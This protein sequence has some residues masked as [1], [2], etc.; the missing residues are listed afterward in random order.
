[1]PAE[2]AEIAKIAKISEVELRQVE[3]MAEIEPLVVFRHGLVLR[4]HA[5]VA[6]ADQRI[7]IAVQQHRERDLAHDPTAASHAAANAVLNTPIAK[8]AF[9]FAGDVDRLLQRQTLGGMK[10]DE[11]M[12]FAH[13]ERPSGAGVV[14]VG[15]RARDQVTY[16]NRDRRDLRLPAS[17]VF[18]LFGKRSVENDTNTFAVVGRYG[19]HV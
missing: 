5:V 2:I 6:V 16:S 7:D 17:P 3:Q 10:W 14:I 18:Q 8:G 1:M 12:A 15:D 13:G 19:L 9:R 4:A 11:G